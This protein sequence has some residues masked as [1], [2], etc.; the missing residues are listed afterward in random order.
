MIR[1]AD[2]IVA[3]IVARNEEEYISKVISA[4][5]S[6]T[7]PLNN[8]ILVDDGSTDETAIIAEKLGC[9]I[10]SL[11]FHEESLVG[12]PDLA[13]R[14]NAGLN[15]VV[16]Y[17]PDY[18]LLMGGDHVL[19]EDYVEELLAKM[20]D[21]IVVASGRI[22]GEGYTEN[23]PRGSGR[24]VKASFWINENKMQYPISHGWESWLLFKA[25][26]IGYEAR[27]FREITSKIER[28]TSL[29]KAKSP[30]KAMYAL[31]YDGK[32]AIGKCFLT[33]FRSPRAGLEIFWGWLRHEN[34]ERLD[35]AAFVN[36][37]QKNRFWGRIWSFIKKGGR[38]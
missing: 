14:W 29:G 17:S 5:K 6:Q 15:T 23:A 25:M 28:P 18:V 31:G 13:K 26:Q 27:C 35:V 34:V 37:M 2:N 7:L 20:T 9:I 36:K 10:I 21:E 16:E 8:I 22:E 33:F 19:P 11:P 1:Q 3:L 4:L 12:N 24:L 38:R 32:Y 30:G